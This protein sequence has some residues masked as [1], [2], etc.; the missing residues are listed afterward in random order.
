MKYYLNS[1]GKSTQFIE[2]LVA[3]VEIAA[4]DDADLRRVLVA[5]V[6]ETKLELLKT[7]VRMVLKT[8]KTVFLNCFS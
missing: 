4:E 8:T 6:L 2:L 5:Q 1:E 7:L 3:E